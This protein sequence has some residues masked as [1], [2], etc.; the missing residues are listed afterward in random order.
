MIHAACA[1][2]DTEMFFSR[3]DGSG[4]KK[5][6]EARKLCFSCP[7]INACRD[8]ADHAEHTSMR[9]FGMLGGETPQERQKRRAS[10][11]ILK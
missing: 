10:K 11:K 5:Y 6:A 8:F 9:P 4:T 3:E 2:A 1:G 7:V